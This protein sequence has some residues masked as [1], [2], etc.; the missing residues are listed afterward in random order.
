MQNGQAQAIV[1]AES[2]QL[3]LVMKNYKTKAKQATFPASRMTYPKKKKNNQ[4]WCG[5][6]KWHIKA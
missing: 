4:K 2:G 1:I 5:K 6:M 3:H